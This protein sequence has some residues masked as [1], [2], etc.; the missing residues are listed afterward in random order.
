VN[1]L[2]MI[3]ASVSDPSRISILFIEGAVTAVSFAVAFAWPRLFVAHWFSCVERALG[4]L[5][6]KQ[7]LAVLIVGLSVIVLRIA[8]LPWIPIPLP[9]V[10]DDFSFLLGADTF[11]HGRLANP[12][13]AMWVHF[14]TIHIDMLPTY[15]SMYFPGQ[16]MFLAA[17][18]VLLGNPWFGQLIASALMCAALCW[19]L[20]A[21]LPPGWALLGGMIAVLRLGLFTYWINTYTGGGCIA[22]LGGALVLGSLPRL[23]RTARSR[24]GALMA[25]GMALLVFTRPY[26]GLLLCL[27]VTAAL[28]H[29]V[30]FGTN[31]PALLILLRRAAIP[32]AILAA[33]IAWLGYYDDRAFGNPLTLPYTVNRTTYAV[34]PYY[35]WESPRP[36]PVYRH[37]AL[38]R[39]YNGAE[40][41]TLKEH[42][43][44]SGFISSS[45]IKLIKCFV[46]FAGFL[47]L[48][49]LVM[50]RRVFLD[51][52]IRFLAI[53]ALLYIPGMLI[54]IYLLP[55]YLAPFTAMFYA[56]GLQAM[57]H[58]RFWTVERKPVGMALVRS[59]VLLCLAF[60][61]L[62]PFAPWVGLGIPVWPGSNWMLWYGPDHYGTERAQIQSRL[63]HLPGNQIAIVRFG[64]QRDDLDQWVYN[65]ADIDHSKVIWAR[66]MDAANNLDL[67]H[68]YK[69]RTPWLI[70]MDTEPATITRYPVPQEITANAH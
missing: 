24:Y 54:Q 34:A 57:R 47:L 59:T 20:Q 63:A 7:L 61:A 23:T 67:L 35:I 41:V 22:A 68:Y 60:A 31:R 16:A 43:G 44:L 42:A 56:I 3:A 40:L 4:S 27:P 33:S 10:P 39:F 30:L 46:F 14:E 29:W 36:E 17:G 48:P 50:I 11:A 25:T 12:T 53:S 58:L 2:A 5:A 8:T 65:S 13:P 19:M 66:E 38:R 18:K 51:R 52:R 45:V 69:D 62:R 26:E 55:H 32:V 70:R 9:F 21:W 64:P 15:V 1:C 6:R 37:E 28:V 49:P